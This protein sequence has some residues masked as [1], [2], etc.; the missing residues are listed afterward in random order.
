MMGLRTSNHSAPKC[1]AGDS[2]SRHPLSKDIGDTGPL[3]GPFLSLEQLTKVHLIP[4][5]LESAFFISIE[6]RI[7]ASRPSEPFSRAQCR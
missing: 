3:A 2:L 1:A 5:G 4:I 7:L 6:A